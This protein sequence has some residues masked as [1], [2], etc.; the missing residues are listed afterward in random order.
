MAIIGGETSEGNVRAIKVD[1][2][3]RLY[4]ILDDQ[5]G[6]FQKDT[7]GNLQVKSQNV[8][9]K[10]IAMQKLQLT[11]QSPQQT[12]QLE[13]PGAPTLLSITVES[14]DDFIEFAFTET[15]SQDTSTHAI[16]TSTTSTLHLIDVE[17]VTFK[18]RDSDATVWIAE[19]KPVQTYEM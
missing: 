14:A 11:N 19:Y 17:Y 8:F 9:Y 18:K 6:I 12:Y 16:A 3:G 15:I 2:E 13:E 4:V 5:K 7:A 1:N 10:P